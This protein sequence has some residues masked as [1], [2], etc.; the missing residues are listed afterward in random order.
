MSIRDDVVDEIINNLSIN[1]V[2]LL[3]YISYKYFEK[4]KRSQSI[5][6]R[7]ASMLSSTPAS[8]R[9]EF[10][11]RLIESYLQQQLP[12][13]QSQPQPQTQTQLEEKIQEED[14]ERVRRILELYKQK[15]NDKPNDKK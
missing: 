6:R 14:I 8:T 5:M 10:I 13:P 2:Y 4:L 1:D 12:H 15:L 11:A 3:L 7:I 9:D